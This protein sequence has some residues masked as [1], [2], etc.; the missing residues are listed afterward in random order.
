MGLPREF[1]VEIAPGY[2][3]DKRAPQGVGGKVLSVRFAGIW[4]VGGE[5]M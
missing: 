4:Q 2:L 5:R 1:G 3:G